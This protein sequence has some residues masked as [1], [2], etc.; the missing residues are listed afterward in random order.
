MKCLIFGIGGQDGSYLADILLEQGHEVHGVYRRTSTGNLSRV[1]HIRNRITLH[2]GDITDAASTSSVIQCLQPDVIYNEADQDDV[3]TSHNCINYQFDVTTRGVV[4]ILEAACQFSPFSKVF[5][6]L[7]ATMF[8]PGESQDIHTRILPRSPYAIAKAAAYFICKYYREERNALVSTG[9]MYNHDSP[10]RGQ[11]YLLQNLVGQALRVKCKEQAAVQV[12]SPDTL[13]DVGHAE[14]YMT[15]ATKI[16][17][18]KDLVDVIVHSAN[19]FSIYYLLERLEQFIKTSLPVE[20]IPGQA[21]IM[22]SRDRGLRDLID[23]LPDT[24]MERLLRGIIAAQLERRSA[25]DLT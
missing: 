20:V 13:V 3:R 21:D 9:I 11:G 19:Q 14:D 7:S 16:M 22:L 18:Q 12:F 2:I 25:E 6:P 17:E 10:R 5:Q 1:E 8:A 4:N 15:A 23:Y 24:S